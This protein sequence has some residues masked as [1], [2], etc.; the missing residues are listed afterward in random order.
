MLQAGM[1]LFWFPMRS[2]DF[3]VDLI[4]PAAV[5]PW[6]RLSL[7]Q[8]WVPI[9]FLG[10]K[11]GRR[12]GLTNLLPSVNRLFRKYGS[13]DVSQTYGPPRPVTRI[14]LP[15]SLHFLFSVSTPHCC[16]II[17]HLTPSSS[18]K[19]I[20]FSRKFYGDANLH[21]SILDVGTLASYNWAKQPEF[22]QHLDG[23]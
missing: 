2:L 4:L 9:S 16:T 1:S 15:F 18:R 5:C 20:E 17:H 21:I 12:I 3:S 10:V 7:Q 13:L 19:N 22:N 14:A 8:K 11:G 23:Q 6:C